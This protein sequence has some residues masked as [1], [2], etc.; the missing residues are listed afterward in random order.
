MEKIKNQNQFTIPASKLNFLY[1]GKEMVH[2]GE[3]HSLR[4]YEGEIINIA[5]YKGLE[6][7]YAEVRLRIWNN[8]TVTKIMK[9]SE[10]VLIASKK[11]SAA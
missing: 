6:G 9:L 4:A 10:V 11:S 8:K 5:Y 3:C 7:P 2:N 1:L